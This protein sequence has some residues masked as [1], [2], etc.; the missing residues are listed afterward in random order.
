MDTLDGIRRVFEQAKDEPTYAIDVVERVRLGIR[1]LEIQPPATR[2]VVWKIS[3][4][5]SALA[6]VIPLVLIVRTY[7]ALDD[8]MIEFLI[9]T[10]G[11]W[12][13]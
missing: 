6:A 11:V 5:A 3:A 8:F 1:P 7:L 13:W 9:P 12:P 10:Q 2:L 4:A